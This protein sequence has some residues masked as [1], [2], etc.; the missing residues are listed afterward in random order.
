MCDTHPNDDHTVSSDVLL[1]MAYLAKDTLI[2]QPPENLQVAL[3]CISAVKPNPLTRERR[4][5]HIIAHMKMAGRGGATL[6][7]EGCG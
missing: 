1:S 4:T 7:G 6:Q 2:L 3:P 5:N